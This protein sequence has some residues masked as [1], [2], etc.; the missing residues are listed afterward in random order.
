MR[1][2]ILL[3]LLG[4]CLAVFSA[5]QPTVS[6]TMAVVKVT[7]YSHTGRTASGVRV[8]PGVVALSRDLERTLDMQFGEKVNLEGLGTFTFHDRMARSKRQQADIWFKS[9]SKAA[10]FG[11]KRNIL[12]VKMV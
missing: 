6:L 7:A 2:I 1:K 8:Q 9:R 12:L 11:V 4:I 10:R 3:S 5:P